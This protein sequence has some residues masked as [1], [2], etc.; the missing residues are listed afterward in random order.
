MLQRSIRRELRRTGQR[1]NSTARALSRTS[2]VLVASLWPGD[3]VVLDK[4]AVYKQPEA[5]AAFQA[6]GAHLRCLPPCTHDFNPIEQAF[7]KPKA[8]LR[9]AWPRT[10]DYVTALVSPHCELFTL[11]ECR[12]CVW[13]CGYGSARQP[14][15]CPCRICVAATSQPRPASQTRK[16]RSPEAD[17]EPP[18][19]PGCPSRGTP[20][21]RRPWVPRCTACRRH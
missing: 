12:Y 1:T 14:D 18:A 20:R 15:S 8:L 7:A 13:P 5:R 2:K 17:S 10:F 19:R 4:L 9:A 16:S 11:A 6:F 3:V 21:L